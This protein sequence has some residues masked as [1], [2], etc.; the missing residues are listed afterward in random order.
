MGTTT[1]PPELPRPRLSNP[2]HLLAFGLGA[3]CSPKAPGT[4]GT[5]MAVVFYLP[6]SRLDPG[7]YLAVVALISVAGVWICGRT[8]RD[9]H[10]PDHP[11]IVWDEIAGFLLT[12][13]GAPRGWGWL[14]AGFLLFR[15][16]DIWKPWPVGWLDRRVHGGLGIMLD[17]LA[18]GALALGLLQAAAR[19]P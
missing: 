9:L 7:A 8:A 11:G 16:F 18:A 12:M 19:L 17:D 3:G 10:Y 15:L 13:T 2:V 6:L 5:L 4:M 1:S 14:V